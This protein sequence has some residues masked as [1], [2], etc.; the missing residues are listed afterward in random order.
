MFK[1][2]LQYLYIFEMMKT[3]I[4]ICAWFTLIIS[5][6]LVLISI[7][8]L[9]NGQSNTGLIIACLF[10]IAA[11]II[12][13]FGRKYGSVEYIKTR[14]SILSSIIVI[15]FGIFLIV[16][17]PIFSVGFFGLSDSYL[18]IRNIIIIFV[19]MVIVAIAILR[20]K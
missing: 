4:R 16:V 19:P 17:I 18:A 10:F 1:L 8:M 7:L 9:L 11:T 13:W 14:I 12:G 6:G 15:L 3:L 20:T 2:I 5:T